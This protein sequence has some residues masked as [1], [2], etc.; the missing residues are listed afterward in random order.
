MPLINFPSKGLTGRVEAG[1]TLHEA[2][3]RLGHVLDYACGGNALC[4]TCCVLV[5]EGERQLTPVTPHEAARLSELG[6][7]APHRLACQARLSEDAKEI[8]IV[9][10]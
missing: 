1:R 5:V 10:C 9:A 3:L 2:V 6:V 4:G 8:T 7:A